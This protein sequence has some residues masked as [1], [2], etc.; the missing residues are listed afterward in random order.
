[1]QDIG[2][3]LFI[4]QISLRPT[5]IVPYLISQVNLL[6]PL[7]GFWA[8]N[9]YTKNSKQRFI[10]TGDSVHHIMCKIWVKQE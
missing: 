10:D 8:T 5:S 6:L 2:K 1:M 7:L 4:Y 3:F 9:E